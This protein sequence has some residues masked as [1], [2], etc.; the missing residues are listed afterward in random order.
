MNMQKLSGEHDEFN[1]IHYTKWK[2][3]ITDFIGSKGKAGARLTAAMEWARDLGR[4]QKVTDSM[5]EQHT[6][7]RSLLEDG[8]V[9]QLMLLMNNWTEGSAD[10]AISVGILNGLDA[11]RKL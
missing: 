1:K 6:S 2:T 9:K 8:D 7:H 5:I 11:W 3:Q 4:D 10:K